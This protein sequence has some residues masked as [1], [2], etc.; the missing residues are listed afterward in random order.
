MHIYSYANHKQ[1]IPL[2]AGNHGGRRGRTPREFVTSWLLLIHVSP[3]LIFSY[4]APISLNPDIP[5]N[6][7]FV[8]W[9][10]K[11]QLSD[12]HQ[13][14]N[15]NCKTFI[16][17]VSL[18]LRKTRARHLVG[19]MYHDHLQFTYAKF[20]QTHPRNTL[21]SLALLS[22]SLEDWWHRPPPERSPSPPWGAP[23]ARAAW[24]TWRAVRAPG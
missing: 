13:I 3:P 11:M 8:C 12:V 7:M 5:E 15:I 22:T 19:E 14:N 20:S 10:H 23:R 24:R 17:A 1:S 18:I 4:L 16:V 21:T 9:E 2:C 6:K